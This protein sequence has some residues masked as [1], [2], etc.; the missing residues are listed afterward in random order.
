MGLLLLI[1]VYFIRTPLRLNL[2]FETPS[3]VSRVMPLFW[4]DQDFPFLPLKVKSPENPPVLSKL[5]GRSPSLGPSLLS[6]CAWR[7][8]HHTMWSLRLVC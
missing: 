3:P 2:C 7:C 8:T 6:L 4:C 5:G 1:N